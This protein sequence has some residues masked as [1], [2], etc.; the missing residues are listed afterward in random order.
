MI[1]TARTKTSAASAVATA[2]SSV[3][4]PLASR[5]AASSSSSARKRIKTGIN[6][7]PSAPPATS[8]NNISGTRCAAMNASSLAPA[9]N[10]ALIADW[11]T[12][13]N[14]PLITYAS[15]T[16]PAARAIW[17]PDN[18]RAEEGESP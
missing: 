10:V 13:P 12:T 4:T 2:T 1:G 16:I 11:R 3:I 8:T 15:I 9:P 17:R 14:T 18:A 5:C 6:A 7:D